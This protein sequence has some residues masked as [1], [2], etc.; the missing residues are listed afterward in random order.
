MFFFPTVLPF[1]PFCVLAVKFNL[2]CAG[3]T[4]NRIASKLH[5]MA[6]LYCKHESRARAWRKSKALN[7]GS[8]RDCILDCKCFEVG[9]VYS[10]VFE[11]YQH[12]VS[13]TGTQYINCG[14]DRQIFAMRY[15]KNLFK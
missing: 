15:F 1:L 6:H 12:I 13:V 11:Q 2:V 14:M 8:G 4:Q 9:I 7:W 3:A 10:F 5:L